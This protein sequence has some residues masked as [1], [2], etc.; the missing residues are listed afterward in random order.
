[1]TRVTNFSVR[2]TTNNFSWL[3]VG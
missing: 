3:C 2:D 1:M